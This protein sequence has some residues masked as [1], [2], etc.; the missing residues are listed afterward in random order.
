MANYKGHFKSLP[1]TSGVISKDCIDGDKTMQ[2]SSFIVIRQFIKRVRKT[3]SKFNGSCTWHFSQ[4]E[5]PV[6]GIIGSLPES[7]RG[8]CEMLAARWIERHA[9]NSSLASWLSTSG[10]IEK[11][12][13]NPSK[14]RQ[15]MQQ[16]IVTYTL[17]SGL[18]LESN[19]G[20]VN[21]ESSIDLWLGRHGILQLRNINY[22]WAGRYKFNE[23]Q[24]RSDIRENMSKGDYARDIAINVQRDLHNC[25]YGNYALIRIFG[26]SGHAMAAWIAQDACFFDPNFGEFYFSDKNTFINWFPYFFLASPYSLPIVG[27]SEWYENCFYAPC[28]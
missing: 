21:Q 10:S 25:H 13:I 2:D 5:N 11:N 15:I 14:I 20:D 16:F 18:I 8:I 6:A 22:S 27:L 19:S 1:G 26:F 28:R 3:V 24:T 23:E 7:R 12:D 4:V 17:K 9:H